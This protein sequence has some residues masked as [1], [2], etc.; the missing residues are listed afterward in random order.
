[1]SQLDSLDAVDRQL[2]NALQSEFPLEPEPFRI[3]GEGLGLTHQNTLDRVRAIKATGLIRY[4]SGIFNPEKLNYQRTLAAVNVPPEKL[5]RAIAILADHPGVSHNYGRDHQY[6]LWFTLSL[7]AT[8]PLKEKTEELAAA[9]GAEAMLYLP[10]TRV[11]KIGVYFDMVGDGKGGLKHKR[12]GASAE[13]RRKVPLTDLEVGAVRRLQDDLPVEARPFAGAAGSLSLTEDEFLA[14]AQDMSR[15]RMMRRFGA[16][17]RHQQA[18]FVANAMGCW[19]VPAPRVEEVGG[20][21]ANFPSVSHC[22][23]RLT[24]PDWPY[25]LFTMIHGRTREECESAAR[26]MSGK[27]GITEYSL[28]FTTKEYKRSRVRYYA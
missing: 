18:G 17:L 1:M 2:L 27:T 26:G 14:L 25:N 11:F 19:V 5:P 10:T 28:L 7:H 22:Y 4:I 24:Y 8:E 20:E 3:V 13:V 21:M 15:R 23:E 6:N 9:I 16:M 12:H